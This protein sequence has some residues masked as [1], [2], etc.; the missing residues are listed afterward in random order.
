M[1]VYLVRHGQT[2][3]N[4][5][6]RHQHSET[7]LNAHGLAQAAAVATEI[8]QLNLTHLITST[9]L[10]AMETARIIGDKIHIIPETEPLFEELHQSKSMIG[11]RLVSV[12]AGWYA[13]FWFLGVPRASM[14]DGETYTAFI[15]RLA[16]A[17]KYLEALPPDARVVVVSH[18]VFINFFLEHMRHPKRMNLIRLII[19][20]FHIL[21]L[22][23]TSIT[24]VRYEKPLFGQTG[25]GW[26]NVWGK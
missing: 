9:Q 1:E 20:A 6:R 24:H 21:T 19:R 11:E 13:A 5:G 17:R 3:G 7:K 14:S 12:H 2:D 25:T 23:N 18:S 15:E 8:V 26:H 16:A 22:K 10:R 4:V